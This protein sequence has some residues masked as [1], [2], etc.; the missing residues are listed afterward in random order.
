MKHVVRILC[1]FILL[2]L[3]V[4]IGKNGFAGGQLMAANRPF[5][6]VIDA[7]HGG[8]D[9]GALGRT[10]K[11]KNINLSVAL[12]FGKLVEKNCPDVKV[13]YTRKK[14]VFVPLERRAE[15]ANKAKADLFIS[16]HTNALPKGVKI[17]GAET[18][19][20]G[21]ARADANFEVAKRENSAILI[22][23]DYEERYQ[24]FNPKSAESYIIFEFMQ[25]KNMEQ[26][27]K[28]ARLIQQEFKTT[29]GRIDK[30]VHQAGFLVLRATS[31]PGALVELGYISTPEE[32]RFLASANGTRKMSQSIYNAF[33]KY[34]RSN[35]YISSPSQT[36]KEKPKTKPTV[37]IAPP[38]TPAPQKAAPEKPAKKPVQ[39]TST[40]SKTSSYPVFKVQILATDRK[41]PTTSSQFKGLKNISC[42]AEGG[43]YKYTYGSTPSY[44]ECKQKQAQIKAKF[45]KAFI[46]AMKD[47]KRMDLQQAIRESKQR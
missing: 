15:I 8:K 35:V 39:T 9:P 16:I 6:L 26:S 43:L 38:N 25:D 30:G 7:G 17:K 22:E 19:T 3:W 24:G 12:A 11:E 40:A 27:V 44:A 20:L 47:G 23:N 1:T 36:P 32:E 14:D 5:T 37:P 46:I 10:A 45:P 2:F 18:Y 34:K 33:L 29:G 31:M 42:Y 4:V 41:I 21:I 28:L 13:I